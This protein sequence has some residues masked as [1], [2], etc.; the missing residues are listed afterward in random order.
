M[1]EAIGSEIEDFQFTACFGAQT[2]KIYDQAVGL[3]DKIDL[4]TMTAGGNDM[5]LLDIIKECVI[6]AFYGE[7]TCNEIL[8]QAQKNLETIIKDNIRQILMALDT[9]MGKDG[10]VVYNGYARFFNE[11]NEDCATKQDWAPFYWSRQMAENKPPLP[12]TIER[13]N[14]FNKLTLALNDAIRD[15]VHEVKDKVKYKIGFANWDLWGIEGVKG[16]MCDPPSTGAYP[17]KE[18]PDL[19]FFKPDTSKSLWRI[20]SPISK[21]LTRRRGEAVVADLDGPVDGEEAEEWDM[22]SPPTEEQREA[23]RAA[24]PPLPKPDLDAK[25]VDRSVYRSSLWNSANPGAEALHTL[26]ARNPAAPGCPSDSSPYVQYLGWM[27]PDYFGRIFHPNEAGH[28]AMA[29]FALS[30]VADLRAEALGLNPQVCAVTDEF[31]CWQKEGRKGYANPDRLNENYKTFCNDVKGPGDGSVAWC[32]ARSFHQGTPD[33]HEFLVETSDYASEYN[34]EE[35]LESM[36]RIIN[37]C[38]GN[39]PENPRNWKFGGTWKRDEY[40]Y[41]VS[42]KRDDRPWPAKEV[43]GTCH[44]W[45]H[46]GASTYNIYGKFSRPSIHS[47]DSG[48]CI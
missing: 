10:I 20:I 18:Q 19:L 5:C 6:L 17:D 27:L 30:R 3:K 47:P 44:G 34:Q 24:L 35:C 21:R 29:S 33:E 48:S 41:T 1:K 14:K 43:D 9:K 28:N 31:K 46:V 16:Q 23:I 11:E 40:R 22:S 26:D 2:N 7:A 13:R 32:N 38:D 25:G 8:A 37:G 39:D 4:L 42:I 12:L 45:Y 36:E 15:V